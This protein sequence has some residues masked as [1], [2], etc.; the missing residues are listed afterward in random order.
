MGLLWIFSVIGFM[1]GPVSFW[2][3]CPSFKLTEIKFP[4]WL[5]VKFSEVAS[6]SYF[7]GGFL[8][9]ESHRDLLLHL[10]ELFFQGT[11][12]LLGSATPWGWLGVSSRHLVSTDGP[13]QGEKKFV[14]RASFCLPFARYSH[15]IELSHPRFFVLIGCLHVA[16]TDSP[17]FSSFS[18]SPSFKINVLCATP[19]HYRLIRASG[20]GV[21]ELVSLSPAA[22][23]LSHLSRMLDNKLMRRRWRHP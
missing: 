19:L 7:R 8:S 2:I 23:I 15:R 16:T 13:K 18:F 9:F 10:F 1:Y 14:L 20:E 17:L 21:L 5:A 22:R 12:S 4:A 11:H 3:V 6:W